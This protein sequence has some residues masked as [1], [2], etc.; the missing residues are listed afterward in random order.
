MK[1]VRRREIQ[2]YG[3]KF[4][5]RL[6][7]NEFGT[8]TS[9]QKLVIKKYGYL[10]IKNNKPLTNDEIDAYFQY[11]KNENERKRKKTI[12]INTLFIVFFTLVLIVVFFTFLFKSL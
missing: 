12:L 3:Y 9:M 1:D 10:L 6:F 4:K 2:D 8:L 5:I 11:I 7:E